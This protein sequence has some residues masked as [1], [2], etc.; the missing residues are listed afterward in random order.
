MLIDTFA[1]ALRV[2]RMREV[3]G[4]TPN[5]PDDQD[6]RNLHLAQRARVRTN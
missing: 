2:Y 3:F 6:T 4:V 1:T 5:A